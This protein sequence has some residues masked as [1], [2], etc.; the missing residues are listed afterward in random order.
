[1]GIKKDF[2]PTGEKFELR[3]KVLMKCGDQNP[4]K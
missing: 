3:K 4:L 2:T 1:V